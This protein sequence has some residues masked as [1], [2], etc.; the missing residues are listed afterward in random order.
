MKKL[1]LALAWLA[2]ASP[3]AANVKFCVYDP[4]G[5]IGPAANQLR[6]LMLEAKSWKVEAELKA[7]PLQSDMLKDFHDKRC[8]LALMDGLQARQYNRFVGTLI[9]PGSMPTYKDLYQAL[10]TLATPAVAPLMSQDGVEVAGIIPFGAAYIHL[11]DRRDNTVASAKGKRVAV[12][13]WDKSQAEFV[14]MMEAVPVATDITDAFVKFNNGEVD[15]VAAPAVTFRALE[16][17]KGLG[18]QGGILRIPLAM[19]V[20]DIVIWK[21]KFPA[22]FG[23]RMRDLVISQM[24]TTMETLGQYEKE[25]PERYWIVV[26]KAQQQEY[27]DTLRQLRLHLKEEG[28]YDPRMLTLLKRIRCKRDAAAAE[29]SLTDE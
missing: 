28:Y 23:Q 4:A 11:K 27:L 9:S 10:S 19:V 24:D 2:A 15:M 1:L 13:A 18:A 22:D 7:Y 29:C 12:L 3:A 21:D 6:D 26:N 25:V 8:D 20:A 5:P 17:K 16:M 14:Q